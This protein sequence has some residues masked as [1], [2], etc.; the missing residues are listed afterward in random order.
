MLAIC[1]QILFE[2][3][4][5]ETLA[6]NVGNELHCYSIGHKS[7]LCLGIISHP[8]NKSVFHVPIVLG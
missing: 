7:K 1:S 3:E 5:V 6:P 2:Y 8:K 4:K